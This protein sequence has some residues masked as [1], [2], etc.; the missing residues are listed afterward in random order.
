MVV[1]W[2]SNCTDIRVKHENII[3]VFILSLPSFLFSFYPFLLRERYETNNLDCCGLV[4]TSFRKMFWQVCNTMTP[5]WWFPKLLS[6][7]VALGKNC[8]GRRLFCR[9][10]LVKGQCFLKG[11]GRNFSHL[12]WHSR[13][14][15]V[16]IWI[17]LASRIPETSHVQSIII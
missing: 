5:G 4:K 1:K 8:T 13:R 16:Y 2:L 7:N 6:V 3:I 12:V 15:L 17:L 10:E 11:K 9:C 14:W